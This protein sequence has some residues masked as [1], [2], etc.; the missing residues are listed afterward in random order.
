MADEMKEYRVKCEAK[1]PLRDN[2]SERVK[3]YAFNCAW[4]A[5]H[6][7]GLSEVLWH[8]CDLAELAQMAANDAVNTTHLKEPKDV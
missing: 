3:A 5:G 7:N 2:V 4:E 8:Y 6:S 1:Y